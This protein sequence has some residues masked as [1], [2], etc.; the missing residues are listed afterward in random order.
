VLALSKVVVEP[1]FVKIGANVLAPNCGKELHLLHVGTEGSCYEVLKSIDLSSITL[2]A[3]SIEYSHL[4]GTQQ[5]E[6]LRLLYTFGYSVLD[7]A[8]DHFAVHEK[9]NQAISTGVSDPAADGSKAL[10]CL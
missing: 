8:G 7:C 5:S 9:A 1:A 6:T 4:S 2:L 3:L 10:T